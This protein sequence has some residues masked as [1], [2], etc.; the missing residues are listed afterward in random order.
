VKDADLDGVLGGCGR[1][2]PRRREGETRG[3][4]KPPAGIR[5]T[6][7]RLDR[8]QHE[9]NPLHLTRAAS[10]DVLAQRGVRKP[11]AKGRKYWQAIVLEG[12]FIFELAPAQFLVKD[13]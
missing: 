8:F 13:L 10:G 7:D 1:N 3:G 4:G 11:C 6:G 9:R 5:S 2:G 12:L